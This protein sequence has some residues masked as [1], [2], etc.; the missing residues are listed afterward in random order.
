MKNFNIPFFLSLISLVY[1][2]ESSTEK[3]HVC[4][5]CSVAAYQNDIYWGFENNQWCGKYTLFKSDKLFYI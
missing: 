3:Y 4:K 1:T 2:K 5:N